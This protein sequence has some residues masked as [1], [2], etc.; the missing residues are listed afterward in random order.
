MGLGALRTS[1][2]PLKYHGSPVVL[3]FCTGL[4]S[5]CSTASKCC[6]IRQDGLLFV[7]GFFGF[8]TAEGAASLQLTRTAGCVCYDSNIHFEE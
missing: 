7:F 6:R 8:L 3:F 1:M 4:C 2:L 5:R